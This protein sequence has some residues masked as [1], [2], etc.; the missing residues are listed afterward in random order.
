MP[1][2][3]NMNETNWQYHHKKQLSL[4]FL[5][6][7]YGRYY[8]TPFEDQLVS[9]QLRHHYQNL[10]KFYYSSMKDKS[11]ECFVWKLDWY[12]YKMPYWAK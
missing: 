3:S 8:E 4:I 9:Y 11:V 12:M 10:P 6:V 1:D 7:D 2:Q 5:T